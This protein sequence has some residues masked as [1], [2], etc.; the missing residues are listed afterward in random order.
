[1]TTHAQ[2]MRGWWSRHAITI[3]IV[4]LLLL[5]LLVYFWRTIFVSVP[6]GHRGVL[7][8]HFTG[9]LTE[10]VYREGLHLIPPWDVMERY[11]VRVQTVERTFSVLTQ[12]G[13][14]VKVDVVVRYRPWEK[15]IGRLHT[16]VGPGYVETV[17]VPEI[18]NAVRAV[19]SRYSPDDLYRASFLDIQ[20]QLVEHA[21]EQIQQRHVYLDDVLVRSI[22]LPPLVS[23]AIHDK[24]TQK[25]AAL[26]MTYRIDR[27]R[28][29]AERKRIEA[30]GVRDFQQIIAAGLSNQY[31]RY[32]GIEATL[33]LA[34]SPNAKI[35]VVGP[36][37]GGLPLIFNADS[38]APTVPGAGTTAPAPPQQ[39]P[40][41]PATA[42]QPP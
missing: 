17:V 3:T 18:G 31:L 20:R 37:P 23:A 42:T 5:L 38:L 12:D 16:E 1:M 40:P 22:V 34:Q 21:R 25:H 33:E 27:E 2:P 8:S 15:L 13:L 28:L 29:E 36:G 14:D 41:A 30:T 32:K 26:E 19:V 10:R 6:A 35:V 4:F 9:T 7:F 24:L 39:G 11:D